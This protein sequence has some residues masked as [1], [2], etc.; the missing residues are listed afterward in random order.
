MIQCSSTSWAGRIILVEW[1]ISLDDTRAFLEHL[2]L[3]S[4]L[5]LAVHTL[6]LLI[7]NLIISLTFSFNRWLL[8]QVIASPLLLALFLVEL[9]GATDSIATMAPAH[10]ARAALRRVLRDPHFDALI[11]VV[12]FIVWL[13][14]AHWGRILACSL[15]VLP[16]FD[17]HTLLGVAHAVLTVV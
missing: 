9:G 10:A 8:I 1:S 2:P 6:N 12:R 3:D 13:C 4:A 11:L 15:F 14:H 5:D 17:S 16:P 7:D